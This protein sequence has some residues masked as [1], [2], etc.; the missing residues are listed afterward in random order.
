VS[1]GNVL[2]VDDESKLSGLLRRIVSLEGYTVYEA[3]DLRTASTLLD[4]EDIEVTVCDVRLPDGNGI[5]FVKE[6][7]SKFPPS[8]I[9]VLTGHGNISDGVQAMKYGAFDYLTKGDDNEKLIPLIAQA[10]EKAQLRR[11]VQRLESKVNDASN[12][13]TIIGRSPALKEVISLAKKV[14][15]AETTILLLGE[16]GTGKELFAKAIHA[17][18]P[19]RGNPFV[20]MNCSAFAGDLLESEVFGH[21][22]GSFTGA[23]KD[24]K[25]LLEEAKGGT[26]FLDEIGEM[27]LDM[28]AKFLRV[29]ETSEFIK[30]GDTKTMLA[31]V[32]IISATNA[33]LKEYIAQGRF[34]EDLFYRLNVFTLYI[35]PLRERRKDIAILARYFIGL[36]ARKMNK[37]ID[38]ISEAFMTALKEHF[39]KGNVRELRNAMERAVIMTESNELTVEHLPLEM[40]VYQTD[41]RRPSSVYNLENLEKSHIQRVLNFTKGNKF[42]AAKLLDIGLTTIYRKIQYYKL[43][44]Y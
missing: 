16:T 11:R 22:A 26:L 23:V 19:R 15:P 12:F 28:Q 33:H 43:Q 14:A 42:E 8:E 24:K 44:G 32:R 29:L 27:N 7:R 38:K 35:P 21:K 18:S 41:A 13:E 17:N 30:L 40:Q 4:K 2:I 34:R 31:D 25:G 1:S 3:Q 6:L 39:W 20:A 9:I 37:K 36:Y 10:I 5:E